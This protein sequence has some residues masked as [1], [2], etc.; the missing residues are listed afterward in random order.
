VLT[1]KAHAKIGMHTRKYPHLTV[2]GILLGYESKDAGHTIQIVDYIPFFHGA[3][4]A[5][6]F[7]MAM[8]L[9]L[10]S[11]SSFSIP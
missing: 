2:N 9:V 5:P 11:Q 8:L 1:A 3:T 7:E 4:L 10:S 6:M